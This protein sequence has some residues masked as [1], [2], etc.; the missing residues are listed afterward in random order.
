[1]KTDFA[2]ADDKTFFSGFDV[3][4]AAWNFGCERF[5]FAAPECP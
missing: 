4:D 2:M 1:M 3:D 5:F